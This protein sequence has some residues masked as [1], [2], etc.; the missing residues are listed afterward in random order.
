[1]KKQTRNLFAGLFAVVLAFILAA[2]DGDSKA[3]AGPAGA[4][5]FA[6]SS[7]TFNPT[8]NFLAGNA[9]TYVNA[10]VGSPFPAAPAAI[11][12]T[13]AYAPNAAFTA[14][15]LTLTLDGVPDGLVL[16]LSN[17]VVSG[18]NV[19]GFTARV[20]GQNYPVTVTGSIPAHTA[21]GGANN[22]SGGSET[23]ASDLPSGVQG[24]Y[25]LTYF[26]AAVG[27][28]I[29]DDSTQTF[30]IGAR[31][32]AFA[33]KTLTN[34]VFVNGNTNEWI[35]KDGALWYAVSRTGGGALNEI[36]VAGPG[37]TP[38]YGQYSD[39]SSSGDGGYNSI[40]VGVDGRYVGGG[41]TATVT[42]IVGPTTLPD[43]AALNVQSLA[44]G[45]TVSFTF[46]NNG[47]LLSP[48]LAGV[49]NFSSSTPALSTYLQ[50][51]PTDT[52]AVSDT[53]A[54]GKAANALPSSLTINSV[55]A[56][57]RTTQVTYTLEVNI[58]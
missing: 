5:S 56:G 49:F 36:N 22:G 7:I 31:T 38:F 46:S 58:P 12:G 14:G 54:I 21:G 44:L 18:G 11:N 57:L 35:F 26:Q 34:P 43:G 23:S 39:E 25:E 45:Q 32:L 27:S 15:T 53:I 55:R 40:G 8:I 29:A 19:T 42:D 37:G 24:T 41:F 20:G 4:G 3:A 48:D 9:L 16:E 33:G 17:F 47:D 2:C 1:M 52:P 51:R 28:G 50:V 13:Y 10:E 30:T 6:G